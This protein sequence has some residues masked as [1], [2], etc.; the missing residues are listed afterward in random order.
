MLSELDCDNLIII[1]AFTP[2][3]SEHVLFI[4]KYPNEVTSDE[5]THLNSRMPVTNTNKFLIPTITVPDYTTCLA[6]AHEPLRIHENPAWTVNES[7]REL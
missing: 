4:L 6:I 1:N 3:L 7:S 2:A 5:I